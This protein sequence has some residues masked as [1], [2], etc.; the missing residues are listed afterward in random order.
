MGAIFLC[1]SNGAPNA[2]SAKIAAYGVQSAA[3]LLFAAVYAVDGCV[4]RQ[5]ALCHPPW[6][7]RRDFLWTLGT[8]RMARYVFTVIPGVIKVV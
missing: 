7:A 5:P 6:N 8:G 2:F 4:S 3:V 1:L